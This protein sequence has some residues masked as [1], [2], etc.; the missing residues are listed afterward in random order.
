[1]W[2]MISKKNN[3]FGVG[4]GWGECKVYYRK[5]TYTGDHK[6]NHCEL[7]NCL[8][9]IRIQFKLICGTFFLRY[10]QIYGAKLPL[11][12]IRENSLFRRTPEAKGKPVIHTHHIYMNEHIF[13]WMLRA[14]IIRI[15]NVE[16]KFEDSLP[17]LAHFQNGCPEENAEK[18]KIEISVSQHLIITDIHNLSLYICFWG[19]KIRWY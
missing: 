14:Q 13:F 4:W 10:K 6:N 16:M 5:E 18:P 7:E 15:C 11:V 19:W 3:D 8:L 9:F 17:L 12:K 1:M 2:Y